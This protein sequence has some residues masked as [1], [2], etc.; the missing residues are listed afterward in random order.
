MATTGDSRASREP[1]GLRRLIAFATLATAA[2]GGATTRNSNGD[3]GAAGQIIEPSSGA[4]ASTGAGGVSSAGSPI[5]VGG[6]PTGGYAG[7]GGVAGADCT[8]AG[9]TPSTGASAL[10]RNRS[11]FGNACWKS[12]WFLTGCKTKQGNHCQTFTGT[13]RSPTSP[14]EVQGAL[15]REIFPVEGV[16]GQHYKVTFMFNALVEAKAYEQGIRDAGSEVPA[17]HERSTVDAFHRDGSPIPSGHNVW[18]LTVYDDKGAEARHYF[19][20][21]FPAGGPR[22]GYWE[23]DRL[24]QVSFTKS[25]VIVGGGFIEHAV[26]DPDCLTVDNCGPDGSGDGSCPDPRSLLLEPTAELPAKYEDPDDRRLKPTLELSAF[27]P[28]F[29]QPWHSQLGHLTVTQ[30][31]ATTDPVSMNYR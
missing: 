24:F 30:I 2:C 10:L 25:I 13:C 21:S 31:E 27:N 28:K 11:T 14:P 9:G 7:L 19:M 15:T 20:N 6:M 1:S 18:K 23:S 3:G 4:E 26:Q 22:P 29:H 17:D 5:L 8:T 16:L 12:S